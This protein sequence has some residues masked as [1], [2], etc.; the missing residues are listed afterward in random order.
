MT[1]EF[2]SLVNEA[3]LQEKRTQRVEVIKKTTVKAQ[4]VGKKCG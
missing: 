3:P 4:M 1:K 2:G